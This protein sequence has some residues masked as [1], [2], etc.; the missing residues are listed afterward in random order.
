[1]SDANTVDRF[2]T[3]I[4]GQIDGVISDA[5]AQ[6][7]KDLL[8]ADASLAEHAE[9]YHQMVGLV[10]GMPLQDPSADF[11]NRVMAAIPQPEMS[12]A[13]LAARSAG[14][15]ADRAST[16]RGSFFGTRFRLAYAF[17]AVAMLA[18]AAIFVFQLAD[19]DP[20]GA[21]G[22]IVSTPDA[23]QEVTV[24]SAE[25]IIS[26]TETGR[27]IQAIVPLDLILDIEVTGTL[28]SEEF[29]LSAE[30]PLGLPGRDEAYVIRLTGSGD[31]M[32]TLR[33][34]LGEI[35]KKSIEIK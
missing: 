16:A 31:M 29:A 6:E 24:G 11:T 20:Q 7:L 1:M 32:T 26:P 21:T 2:E 28:A 12:A 34:E 30:R 33:S 14:R 22:T 19:F 17:S 8:A 35:A 25:L 23:V 5:E 9:A 10:K 15:A 4:Q 27:Q 13:S 18:V 3:L